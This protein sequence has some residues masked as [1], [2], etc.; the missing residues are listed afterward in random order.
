MTTTNLPWLV[1]AAD[2]ARLIGVSDVLLMND[3]ETI[4]VFVIVNDRVALVGAAQAVLLGA[5]VKDRERESK[6]REAAWKS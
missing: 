4:P 2:V 3:I 5:D 1:E 6:R